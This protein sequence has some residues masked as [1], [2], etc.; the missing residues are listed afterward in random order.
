MP[1]HRVL[2]W[3]VFRLEARATSAVRANRFLGHES[4]IATCSCRRRDFSGELL[5][6]LNGLPLQ[7]RIRRMSVHRRIPITIRI[8]IRHSTLTAHP[9]VRQD[10]GMLLREIPLLKLSPGAIAAHNRCFLL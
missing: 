8:C 1:L 10:A 4:R 3:M 9:A 5:R 7:R 6:I 2:L